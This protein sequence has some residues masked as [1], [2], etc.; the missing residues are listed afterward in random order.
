MLTYSE[1]FQSEK[2]I[3]FSEMLP[4]FL[5]NYI[6]KTF[7]FEGFS[8]HFDHSLVDYVF[9]PINFTGVNYA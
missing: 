5:K 2:S 6:Y 1:F 7:K 3:L 4:I 8:E 9:S